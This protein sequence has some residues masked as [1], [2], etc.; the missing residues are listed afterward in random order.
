MA[1]D[2]EAGPDREPDLD[3]EQRAWLQGSKPAP[4]SE[5]QPGQHKRY[6]EAL[7]MQRAFN[8]KRQKV[9]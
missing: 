8:L 4:D 7:H 3:E 5:Q 1:V 9:G 2:Q 6:S